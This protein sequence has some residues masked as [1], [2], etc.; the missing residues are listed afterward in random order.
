MKIHQDIVT[1]PEILINILQRIGEFNDRGEFGLELLD[2]PFLSY[3]MRQNWPT[4]KKLADFGVDLHGKSI[5]RLEY[6]LDEVLH[7]MMTGESENEEISSYEVLRNGKNK[8]VTHFFKL[9]DKI[10][11]K[12]YSVIPMLQ[13]MAEQYKENEQSKNQA[14]ADKEKLEAMLAKKARGYQWYNEN[15]GKDARKGTKKVNK[16]ANFKEATKKSR[17]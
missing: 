15:Y 6:D 8:E 11:A 1:R 10:L 7:E 16:S 2:N 17:K 14:V 9:Y 13:Q 5:T 3:I 4:V 12:N